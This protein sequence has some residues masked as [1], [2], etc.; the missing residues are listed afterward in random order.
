[1]VVLRWIASASSLILVLALG[2]AAPPILAADKDIGAFFGTYAG[3][4]IRRGP[5]AV[6]PRDLQV[7]IRATEDGFN[8]SWQ[9][10]IYDQAGETRQKSYSINFR[11]T[12]RPGIFSSQMR[13]NKF[14]SMVPHDPFKGDPFIWARLIGDTLTVYALHITDKGGYEM[15][16]YDRTLTPE[17]MMVH[18]TRLREGQLILDIEGLLHRVGP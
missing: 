11:P 18:F 3:G 6:S 17:G 10:A 16:V 2:L 5:A 14:G 13:P 4:T 15:Q 8:V 12:E 9:T 1:M 7:T